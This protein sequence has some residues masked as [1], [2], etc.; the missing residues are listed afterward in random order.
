MDEVLRILQEVL[1]FI[2]VLE[3]RNV[4]LTRQFLTNIGLST[5]FLIWPVE[6]DYLL[7]GQN[8]IIF[9]WFVFLVKLL[10]D[11]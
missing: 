2:L 11:L 5:V 7:T 4:C 3:V 6:D 8:L 9:H 1:M 10:P